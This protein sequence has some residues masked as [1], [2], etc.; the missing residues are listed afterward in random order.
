MIAK[1]VVAAALMV[2]APWI[3]DGPRSRYAGDIA[4]AADDIETAHALIA[5]GVAESDFRSTIEHCDCAENEC[6]RD[7]SGKPTAVGL[8][9]LHYYHWNGHT[10]AQICADNRLSTKLAARALL[11]LAARVGT[12]REALRV[13]VGAGVSKRDRRIV[14]RLDIFDKLTT[15]G[16]GQGT[17]DLLDGL[18]PV[19]L[20]PI[21]LA[22]E[23][24]WRAASLRDKV[25]FVPRERWQRCQEVR[26]AP[27]SSPVRAHWT[28]RPRDSIAA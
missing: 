2:A 17:S 12:M 26:Q 27:E 14:K 6:D 11:K 23:P 9:Q 15:E 24:A 21:R 13:Y 22:A 10:P 19:P 20:S 5:T 7:A 18:A 28:R 3:K 16:A 4:L 8:Y 25:A 1:A